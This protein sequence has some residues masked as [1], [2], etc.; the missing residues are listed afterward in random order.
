MNKEEVVKNKILKI[1]DKISISEI[2][3][4]T[5]KSP[6]LRG[7]LLG[8]LAEERFHNLILKNKKIKDVRKHDDHDRKNNKIDRD[9]LYNQKHRISVQLKSIQTNSIKW[10]KKNKK[11]T[12][13]VQN[14]ASCKREIVLP[15]GEKIRTT[16]YKIGDYDIL[17]VPLYP[18][19]SKWI[20]A[21]K[22]NKNCRKSNY[23][24]Y[25]ESQKKYLL[26]TTEKITYPL[27]KE[28]T[29]NLDNIIQEVINDQNNK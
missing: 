29:T 5:K 21:Y 9:F 22:L 7:I 3:K 20:Y 19:C 18:F 13:I 28:W 25:S 26:S 10:D 2:R 16:N 6:S 23:K 12:A 1:I 27:E 24:K 4:I 14:D 8:Y 17:A 15:N 11:F